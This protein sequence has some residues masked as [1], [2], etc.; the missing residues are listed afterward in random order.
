MEKL[1]DTYLKRNHSNRSKIARQSGINL[2][3]IK[4]SADP[5]PDGSGKSA[6]DINPRVMAAIA[7]VFKKTPGQVYDELIELESENDMTTE[8]TKLLLINVLDNADATALVTAEDMGDKTAVIAEIDLPSGE[9][10][11]FS[12]NNPDDDNITRFGVLADLA[13]A[14]ADY[15]HEDDG[16][17]YPTQ[18]EDSQPVDAE[19]M[20]VSSADADYLNQLSDK[21]LKA[22][23]N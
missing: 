2:N 1:L 18:H 8:E 3:T 15:D 6:T 10:I 7:Q 17:F 14:M 19:Y 4:R 23:R 12:V 21:V 9:T 22:R 13:Y 16:E 5:Y 11:R 20:G